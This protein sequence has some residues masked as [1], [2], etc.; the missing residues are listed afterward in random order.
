MPKLFPLFHQVFFLILLFSNGILGAE[1]TVCQLAKDGKALLKITVSERASQNTLALADELA[2]YL[3]KISGAEFATEIGNG[4]SGLVIG[5]PEDFPS[6]LFELSFDKSPFAREQY[7]IR[8]TEKSLYLLGAT[9]LA[10]SHAVWDL[11]HRLGYRQFF[12]GETWEYVPEIADLHIAVDDLEEPAFYARRIWYNWGLWGYNEVPYR[13]WCRRNR[14]AKGFDLQS[15]HAYDSIMAANRK[16]FEKHPEYFSMIDGKRTVNWGD[17][18]FC[19]SNPGLRKLVVDYAV[20]DF[21]ENPERDSISM[22]PSDG[23]GWCQCDECAKL[24]SPSNRVV[25]LAT[26]VAEAIKKLDLGEKAIGFYAYN[27]HCSPPTI[28]MPKEAIP[29]VTTAFLTGGLSFDQV[30][31][32]WQSQGAERIGTYDYLSVAVWDWNMPRAGKGSQLTYLSEFLPRI[33]E[34]GVRFY[35]AESGD[36]WGPCGLGYYFASRVLWN[37]NESQRLNEI[38]ED[39]LEKYFGPAREPMREFYRLIHFDSQ[40][41][42]HSDLVGRMYRQINEAR[43]FTTDPIILKRLDDLTLYTRYAELYGNYSTKGGTRDDVTR[44][45]YKMRKTMMIH[46]YGFLCYFIGQG[47]TLN[48]G[49]P[50]FDDT[51]YS[52]EEIAA[53]LAEG[54]KNNTPV[55]PGFE[56]VVYGKNLVPAAKVL[57]LPETPQGYFPTESQDLQVYQIYLP[58]GEKELELKVTVRPLW[59]S[60]TT[61]ISMYSPSEVTVQTP[62]A[63]EEDYPADGKE[64][65]IR[66]KSPFDGLHNIVVLDGGDFTKITWPEGLPVSVESDI[67]SSHTLSHFRGNW[68]LYFYVPRGTKQIGGWASRIASWAPRTSGKMLDPE[69]KI[70]HDFG[71]QEE[72]WFCVEVSEGMDG[73]VWKFQ[74]NNG[75]RL[76]MTVPPYLARSVQE[77]LLPEEVVEKDAK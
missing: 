27:E 60:R 69:G 30:L 45:A 28:P 35:D 16:E 75:Q 12:P 56:G 38:V 63:E 6:L 3:T 43:K 26:E 65:T 71:E 9:D 72:G 41:R 31:D 18:K 29:S 5:L 34:K 7:L 58:E 19:I 22:D 20:R 51:P 44:H 67:N 48:P 53:F 10:V 61:K 62:V 32:G 76:L 13:D 50:L 73:K 49:N 2:G 74:D 57:G 54:P 68:T 17:Q 36:C 59:K 25:I 11:L 70:R 33:H 64:H 23:G 52:A 14:M 37:T 66:L 42:P 15:G 47:E 24:G 8:S 4:D 39:F 46:S 40:R 21:R 77:L 1:P 55:D